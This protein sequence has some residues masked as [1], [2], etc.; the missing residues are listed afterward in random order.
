VLLACIGGGANAMG[1][2]HDF[3][4]SPRCA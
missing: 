4:E 1:Q 3:V 2:F